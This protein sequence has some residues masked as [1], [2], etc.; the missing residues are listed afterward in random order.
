MELSQ[1]T[2]KLTVCPQ[3]MPQ[4]VEALKARGFRAI[5][6]NRPDGEEPGQPD[7]EA[8]DS[9]AQAAGL[10]ARYIPI[11]GGMISD[12]DV[13]DFGKALEDLPGPIL[14]YCRSGRRSSILWSLVEEQNRLRVGEPRAGGF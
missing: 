1:L 14:A 2:P 11:T 5:I 7:F 13:S 6:C 9:A 3:I 8:I 12:A 4:D 10:V